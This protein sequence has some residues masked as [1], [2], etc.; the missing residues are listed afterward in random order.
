M[1]DL[2]ISA[3][4]FSLDRT[5]TE[6]ILLAR[7]CQRAALQ[8]GSCTDSN[9]DLAQ[10]IGMHQQTVSDLINQLSSARLIISSTQGERAN[11]RTLIPNETF[12]IAYKEFTD[13]L[14]SGGVSLAEGYKFK[15][16]R[17]KPA[18]PARPTRHCPITHADITHQPPASIVINNSTARRLFS[19]DNGRFNEL[20]TQLLCAEDA[21]ESMSSRCCKLSR[22]ARKL[23]RAQ[24]TT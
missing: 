20:V 22:A 4:V 13:R 24:P 9:K 14:N 18:S 12:S 16:Y 23:I 10:A 6:R 11:R 5:L 2:W 17:Q 19:S 15:A 7:I 1:N 8:G 21:D 3:L